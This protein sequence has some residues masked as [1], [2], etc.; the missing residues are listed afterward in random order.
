MT[1][2]ATV[3]FDMDDTLIASAAARRRGRQAALPEGISA[4][5]HA[6]GEWLWWR[7]YSMGE[8]SIEELRLGRWTDVG[9]SVAEAEQADAIYR[10]VAGQI[11]VRPHARALL[12][13]LRRRGHRLVVLTN[14]TVDPQRHKADR[15][16]ISALVDAVLV[17][18][19]IG[20][21]KPHPKAFHA[22]LDAVGGSPENA[23]MVG[24]RRDT[25]ID[26]ALAAGLSRAVWIS[27]CRPHPDPRVVTVR[28][29]S[30]MRDA[31]LSG[32]AH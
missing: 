26:G 6:R 27:R 12:R 22:A 19:E 31:L 30:E 29:V 20:K 24:D 25:D 32:P 18:E 14:G 4:S 3:I 11:R 21:H 1:A 13:E 8:C 7:R 23:L 17:T 28:G 10:R 15:L 16:G 2:P 9:L 5:L